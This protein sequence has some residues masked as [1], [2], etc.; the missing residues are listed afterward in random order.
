MKNLAWILCAA[1]AACGGN[2]GG[3]QCGGGGGLGVGG[4][5]GGRS[6]G[7]GDTACLVD[8]PT[9]STVSYQSFTPKT[10]SIGNAVGSYQL[11]ISDGTGGTACGLSSDSRT[12]LGVAGHEI[13]AN[14]TYNSGTSCSPGTYS[15]GADCPASP[16][17]EP[18]VQSGCAYYR[19]FDSSG[20]SMGFAVA[21]AGSVTV[22]GDYT[23]CTFTVNLSFSGTQ[24]N[25]SFTLTNGT[26]QFPWCTP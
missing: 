6:S 7:N 17:D 20:K 10:R 14:L 15:I 26:G 13:L 2:S 4:G 23:A 22:S 3:S 21:T 8:G 25:D 12:S 1:L 16:M 19:P 9:G 24:F 18:S 11:A 5:G